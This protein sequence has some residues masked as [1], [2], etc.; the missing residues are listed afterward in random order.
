MKLTQTLLIAITL[1]IASS[2]VSESK[3][4]NL[5]YKYEELER[6]YSNLEDDYENKC[7]EVE[8]L[9]EAYDELEMKYLYLRDEASDVCH[10]YHFFGATDFFTQ[11]AIRNLESML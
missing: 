9:H 1:I 8:E 5:E 2:C 11:V 4:E 10:K 3:Y 6:K 7:Q